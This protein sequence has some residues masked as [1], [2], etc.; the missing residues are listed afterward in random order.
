MNTDTESSKRNILIDTTFL[1]DQ[2]SHRGIGRYGKE[3]LRRMIKM[4]IDENKFQ[5]HLIGFL[6]LHKNMMEMKFSNLAIEEL[7]RAIKFHSLGEP[8][9]SN[10]KNSKRWNKQYQPVIE[11][12]SPVI[13]YAVHFERGLPSVPVFKKRVRIDPEDYPKTVVTVHDVIPLI[14]QKFSSKNLIINALKKQFY[15][16]MFK[17]AENADLILSPSELTK[18]DIVKYTQ[19]KAENIQV[20]YLGVDKIFYRENYRTEESVKDAI[21]NKFQIKDKKYFFYDSGLEANK[22]GED[23]INITAQVFK[24]KKPSAEYIVLTASNDLAQG[25]GKEIKGKSK[26]GKKFLKLAKKL[27]IIDKLIAVGRITD[28]ELVTILFNARAYLYF[29]HYEGFGFGPVQAMAAE[30]PAIGANLSCIP[31]ITKGGALL[32]DISDPA[33]S[34]KEIVKHLNSEEEVENYRKK[35]LEIAKGY[36]WE[37]TAVRTWEAIKHVI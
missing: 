28:E 29:S 5:L 37:D 24:A 11:E 12:V 36:N 4:I 15:T 18:S 31:E 34:A 22:G 2:Y 10:T 30:V 13:F 33:G 27:G 17:G 26:T 6:D 8:I 7:S 20:I 21:L 16:F 9:V 25:L 35:G 23:L 1:F 19:I 14:N 32:V 3:L